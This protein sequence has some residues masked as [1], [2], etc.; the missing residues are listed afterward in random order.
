M[1]T[2]DVSSSQL[3]AFE[4]SGS[5]PGTDARGRKSLSTQAPTESRLLTIKQAANYLNAHVWFIRT[6]VWAGAI[7][8]VRF[9]KRILIDRADLDAFIQRQKT[10][11]A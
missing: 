7:P 11:A 2:V 9:G 5:S 4:V 1:S 3:N 6:Q 10:A 8:Y